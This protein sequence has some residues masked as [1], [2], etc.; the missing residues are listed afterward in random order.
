M[1][2]RIPGRLNKLYGLMSGDAGSGGRAGLAPAP[3]AGDAA[4]GKF[5]SGYGDYRVPAGSGGGTMSQPQ[6]RVTLQTG[7]AVMV[8]TQSAKTTVY[9]TPYAGR[10]VPL[11][12]GSSSF[13][14]TDIGGEISQATTD[15][16]KSPAAVTTNSNYDLFVWSDAGT[17]RCT[18]GPA[19]TSDTARGTGAGTTELEL[20]NG[21]Y[22]N[23]NAITNG[24]AARRGT[25][26]GTV[27]SNGSSQVDYILGG[28]AAGGTAAVIGIWNMYNRVQVAPRVNDST[29]SWSYNS[30][31]ARA[32]NNSNGNRISM[33]RGLD[34]D[35]VLAVL[36]H[37]FSGGA[38]GDYQLGVSL[39]STS[40]FSTAG[41]YG[42]F[43][44]ASAPAAVTYAGLPG[45]GF[46]YLQC[47]ERQVTT[48]SAATGFGVLGSIQ[49]HNFTA[50]LRA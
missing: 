26:V 4:A 8:T 2:I 6:G 30:T 50:Q 27:R 9:Y 21:V 40:T 22:V 29:A 38:S 32:M 20:L 19:W 23:K 47:V 16:T 15:A 5:L 7:V 36:Q 45:L 44:T 28:V 10:Y 11:W 49:L 24:P 17:Y 18:R 37:T 41:C 25:F 12:D 39:D 3:A 48:A 35:G 33:V 1:A 34:E 31:T 43:G 46:H 14:M 13:T 42:S